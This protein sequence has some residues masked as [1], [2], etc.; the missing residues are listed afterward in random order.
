M[1]TSCRKTSW[2]GEAAMAVFNPRFECCPVCDSVKIHHYITTMDRH[3][4]HIDRLFD[5]Y[6]CV[7]CSLLFLN[8]MIRDEEL[9]SM[10]DEETY[11][12]Y[13][14]LD[15]RQRSWLKE[16]IV[17]NL[18]GSSA[19]EEPPIDNPQ[20]KKF[21]DIGCG[22]GYKLYFMK[23]LGWDVHGVEISAVAAGIGNNYGLNIAQGTLL[24]AG[25]ES[26]YFDYIRS[27]HS[28]EHITNPNETMAEI[29]RI[30]KT[31]GKLFIGVP[32]TASF[33]CHVFREYWFYL[34][35][36]FHPYNY[37]PHNLNLL[38]RKWGFQV[39]KVKYVGNWQG[40][41][42]SLKYLIESKYRLK[43][44]DPIYNN[45]LFQIF[46]HQIARILNWIRLGDCIE[47]YA[48]KI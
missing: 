17:K 36:P 9:F 2:G 35:V 24:D 25:Y 32:N 30:C 23:Q 8:P 29:Q 19:P 14:P 39:T 45:R 33:P 38:L 47:I 16:L 12:S 5:V 48:E 34:G 13:Q 4:G 26:E 6:L 42:G 27:N 28:F 41:L 11:Y 43:L 10:Y 31:G 44:I 1:K 22:S 7:D 37:N 40:L 20:G 46:F 3:Y 18:I 21:L 15:F